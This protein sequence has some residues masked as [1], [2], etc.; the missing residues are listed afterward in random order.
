MQMPM[1]GWGCSAEV[2]GVGGRGL[3]RRIPKG[4]RSPWMKRPMGAREQ[5]SLL[6]DMPGSSDPSVLLPGNI[7][8]INI[9]CMCYGHVKSG[10][11]NVCRTTENK[12]KHQEADDQEEP[13]WFSWPL[14]SWSNLQG[15]MDRPSPASYKK[16]GS[17]TSAGH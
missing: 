1:V 12:N 16:M 4:K 10:P 13:T 8:Q 15:P 3:A 9:S 6:L 14:R 11:Y 5:E 7:P 17:V 2:V